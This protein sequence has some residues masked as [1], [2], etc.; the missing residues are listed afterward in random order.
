MPDIKLGRVVGR[1]GLTPNIQIGAVETLGAGETAYF[2]REAGSP[3]SSPVFNVGLPRG[4]N[5]TVPSI[6]TGSTQI[7]NP[8]QAAIIRRPGSPDIAPVFDF[9]VPKGD[10]GPQGFAPAE[11]V[12][13]TASLTLDASHANK[14]LIVDST[15]DITIVV[16]TAAK[17]AMED[18]AEIEVF[19]LGVGTVTLLPENGVTFLCKETSYTIPDQYTS[20][21][22]KLLT[23]YDSTNNTWAVQGAIG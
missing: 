2:E 5:G 11:N 19:R 4:A 14:Q 3:D 22:L 17:V 16:P 15:D 21:A 6:Q 12:L 23:A 18:Y 20:A 13:I 9:M 10:R 1:D 8:E 7:V